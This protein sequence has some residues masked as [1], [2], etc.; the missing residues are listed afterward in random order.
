MSKAKTKEEILSRDLITQTDIQRLLKVGS[1]RA[2][3]IFE[4][5][6]KDTEAAGKLTV[7]DL[8]SWRRMYRVLGL[9]I[10]AAYEK[11]GKEANQ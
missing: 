6:V 10:P 8:V 7:P 9:P 11:Q 1:K 5:V 2:K 3:F 4:N